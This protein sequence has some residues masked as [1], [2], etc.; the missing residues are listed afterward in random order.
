M[1]RMDNKV[2]KPGNSLIGHA[3]AARNVDLTDYVLTSTCVQAEMDLA[4]Q[5]HFV[6]PRE[7]VK[8]V[9]NGA[10]QTAPG[11]GGSEAAFLS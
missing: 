2:K 1:E 11:P 6:L 8:S 5:N 4:D 9:C 3:A 7:Q 10:R